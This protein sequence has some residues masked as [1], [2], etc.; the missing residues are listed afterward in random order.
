VISKASISLTVKHSEPVKKVLSSSPVSFAEDWPK[1][2]VQL[3][4]PALQLPETPMSRKS[5]RSHE[6]KQKN[7]VSFI[8]GLTANLFTG[9]FCG[10]FSV[11]RKLFRLGSALCFPFEGDYQSPA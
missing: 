1:Q 2:E 3:L 9:K 11:K 5:G 4:I 6:H 8:S 7:A 10:F